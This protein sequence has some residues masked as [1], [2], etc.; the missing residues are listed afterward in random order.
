[1]PFFFNAL[2]L[3]VLAFVVVFHSASV[4]ASSELVLL[5]NGQIL[6]ATGQVYEG[7]SIVLQLSNGEAWYST[8]R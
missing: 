7:H 4:Q 6:A 8:G 2:R 5:V 1:M 3:S